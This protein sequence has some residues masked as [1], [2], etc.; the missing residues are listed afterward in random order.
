MSEPVR[1]VGQSCAC[2]LHLRDCLDA[3]A[4]TTLLPDGSIDV[5]VTSPPYN[6]GIQYSRYDD[7]ISRN[8]YLDWLTEWAKL[9]R[10]VLADDGSVFLNI[11]SKPRDPTVPF[12]VLERMQ[13][14]FTLQNTFHWIKSVSIPRD[15]LDGASTGEDADDEDVVV[16][17]YKPINSKRFVNDCH[18]YI[19]HLTKRGDV[20]LDRLAIGVPYRDKSNVARWKQGGAGVHCRGN[21]WFIPY[22]TISSRDRHRPHPATFPPELPQMCLRLHGIDRIRRVMD[23]FMG[24]GSTAVGCCRLGLDFVGFEIDSAYFDYAAHAV[25]ETVSADTE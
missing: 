23:P 17:H 21:V 3:L 22:S 25:S 18:E 9:V 24:L 7:T 1:I 10:R 12:A 8:E 6:L 13:Q 2:E 4:D 16:G 5:V 11:G 15:A 20:E 19:F 14:S